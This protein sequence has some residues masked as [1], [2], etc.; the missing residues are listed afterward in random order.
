MARVSRTKE[1]IPF[2][3]YDHKEHFLWL[4]RNNKIASFHEVKDWEK[5]DLHGERRFLDFIEDLVD[6]HYRFQ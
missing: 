6:S 4:D 1:H 3:G 5:M 2:E